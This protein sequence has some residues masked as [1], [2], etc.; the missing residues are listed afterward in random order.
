MFRH[1]AIQAVLVLMTAGAALAAPRLDLG[2]VGGGVGTVSIPVTL[3]GGQVPGVAAAAVDIGYDTAMLEKPVA[4][5]GP[6][7][8][9]AGKN[10]TVGTPSPGLVR[11]AIIGYNAT[12]IGDGVVAVVT[13]TRKPGAAG[14]VEFKYAASASDPAG[15]AVVV[16]TPEGTIKVK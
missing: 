13:F 16:D 14:G 12:V 4:V 3:T 7:A 1:F 9:A 8:L 2:P 6:A 10:V 15:T 11:V 5:A